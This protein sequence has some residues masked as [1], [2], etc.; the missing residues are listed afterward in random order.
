MPTHT[1]VS[2]MAFTP[3]AASATVVVVLASSPS[4]RY[5]KTM[6]RESVAPW[7]GAPELF[8][9]LIHPDN[10]LICDDSVLDLEAYMSD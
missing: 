1:V 6:P 7:P 9:L 4:P 2:A 10:V 3:P 5:G 8:A